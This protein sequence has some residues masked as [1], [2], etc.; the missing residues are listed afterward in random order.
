M[1]MHRTRNPTENECRRVLY[2]ETITHVHFYIRSL[3]EI[4]TA[5][6]IKGSRNVKRN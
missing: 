5:G 4:E 2:S 6:T 1:H 3:E